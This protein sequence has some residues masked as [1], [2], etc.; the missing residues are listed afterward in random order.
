MFSARIVV[1]SYLESSENSVSAPFRG[2]GTYEDVASLGGGVPPIALLVGEP[3]QP[4]GLSC[5]AG[6][7]GASGMN[8]HLA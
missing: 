2:H 5:T 8:K 3:C 4:H 7:P 1:K 6:C